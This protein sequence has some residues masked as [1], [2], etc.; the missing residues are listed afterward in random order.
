MTLTKELLPQKEIVQTTSIQTKSSSSS[1]ILMLVENQGYPDD[2][3]VRQEAISLSNAGYQV[4]VICQRLQGQPWTETVDEVTVYR[5]PAPVAADSFIGY[6][7]EYGYSLIAAFILSLYVALRQGIDVIHAHNPP[8]LYVFIG[9]F[10]K[11]FG[12]KFIF[13]HH[14]L[15][16][17]N[18]FARFP[19]NNGNQK[20]YRVLIWLEALSCRVADH[21]IAT[22]ES[23]KAIQ[24]ERAHIPESNVTVVRNGPNLERLYPVTP[25]AELRSRATTLIG[26][27]GTMGPQDGLDYLLR[28]AHK[29]IHELGR[30]DFYCVVI[31]SGSEW[32]RLQEL[33]AELGLTDHVWFTGKVT[34]EE[35]RRYL[36]SVDICVSVDPYNSFT[37]HCTMIKMMEYMAFGK[38]IVAFDLKE[39]RVTAEDAAIYIA[40][41]DELAFARALALLMDDSS[42]RERHGSF[43][44]R[45]VMDVINW[46]NSARNLL[47]VYNQ[48]APLKQQEQIVPLAD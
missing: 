14:D 34:D 25:D 43:G 33:N 32:D 28:I 29:L 27:I 12:V 46:E 11:P 30:T 15:S 40:D 17:E 42:L 20:V 41:N 19:N 38:P 45:R 8:D 31:G 10:Y 26:Y 47:Q 44:H 39:H 2:I 37:D 18:Y 3:R 22:N 36:S 35:L 23:Y 16:P 4:S 7:W 5:Y 21:V 1:K 48:V 9:L 24:I 6:L 13:D